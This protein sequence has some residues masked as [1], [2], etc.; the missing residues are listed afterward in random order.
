MYMMLPDM[1]SRSNRNNSMRALSQVSYISEEQDFFGITSDSKLIREY[2]LTDFILYEYN[3][4]IK[5]NNLIESI[6]KKN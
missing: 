4:M 6:S 3:L 1:K 2:S 5:K